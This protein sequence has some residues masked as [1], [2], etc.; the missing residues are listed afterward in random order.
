MLGDQRINYT[1]TDGR[2]VIML[3][4][5][6][7]DIIEADALRPTSAYAGNLYSYEYF[8]LLKNHLAPGGYAVTWS[9]TPRTVNT[10]VKVFP[11][12]LIYNADVNLLIG[13]NEPIKWDIEGI[14]S[15]LTSAFARAYYSPAGIDVEQHLSIIEKVE[16]TVITP[17]GRR[18]PMSNLNRDLFPRDE[19]LVP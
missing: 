10:F 9:P 15:R 2:S 11:H 5:E 1:F 3:G 13:S 19:Y 8:T 16:P 7:Y 12:V 6:K 17:E 18:Q 14:R 4:G